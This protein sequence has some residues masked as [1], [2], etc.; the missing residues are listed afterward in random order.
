[1]KE[2]RPRSEVLYQM[3]KAAGGISWCGL[4][5]IIPGHYQSRGSRRHHQCFLGWRAW[6]QQ[7]A[8]WEAGQS[9]AP[10]SLQY[11]CSA[12]DREGGFVLWVQGSKAGSTLCS[13]GGAPGWHSA[14][15]LSN[16]TRAGHGGGECGLNGCRP[17]PMLAALSPLHAIPGLCG[18][19]AL[20]ACSNLS[21][22]SI[23]PLAPRGYL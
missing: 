8:G 6:R 18:A 14:G 22:K 3:P 10:C 11:S 4:R 13:H 17:I 16:H 15:A 12:T 23:I 19:A 5:S 21:S 7:R 9:P 2:R 1:M 20:P